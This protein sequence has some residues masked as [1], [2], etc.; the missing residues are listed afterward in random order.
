MVRPRAVPGPPPAQ[1]RAP[2][3]AETSPVRRHRCQGAR[4]AAGGGQELGSGPGAEG[5]TELRPG[6]GPCV[7]W[8]RGRGRPRRGGG[9]CVPGAALRGCAMG[10][11]DSS[12]A[13]PAEGARGV[14]PPKF[15]ISR[16]AVAR[17]PAR[18]PLQPLLGGLSER[19]ESF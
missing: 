7:P 11:A 17:E 3:R 8:G 2:S 13:G 12:D 18:A 16:C 6:S 10:P 15:F 5:R 4:A 14:L 1:T 9:S 19:L